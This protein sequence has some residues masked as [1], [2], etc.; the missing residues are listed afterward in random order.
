MF[1]FLCSLNYLFLTPVLVM[2]ISHDVYFVSLK[3]ELLL[4]F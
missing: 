3:Q 2:A 1:S 4:R